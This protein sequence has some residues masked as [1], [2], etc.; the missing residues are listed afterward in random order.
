M[1][2]DCLFCKIIRGEIP[3]EKIYEDEY[4]FAFLDI[5]PIN[6]GHTLVIPKVHAENMF[7][8]TAENFTALMKTVHRLAPIVKNAVSADGVNIGIN[9]GRAAGQLVF[10]SHVHII[11]RFTGDGFLHW[12]GAPLTT[13]EITGVA[14]QIQHLIKKTGR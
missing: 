4:A 1:N 14:H 12:H 7:D 5:H 10:H 6:K 8:I 11:P 2:N 9:N 3:S 13:Q